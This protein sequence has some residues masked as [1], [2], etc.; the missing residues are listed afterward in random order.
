M[1]K[2]FHDL[3]NP[4]N[5]IIS[6]TQKVHLGEHNTMTAETLPLAET[7][8]VGKAE[9]VMKSDQKCSRNSLGNSCVSSDL[10]TWK[11]CMSGTN[12]CSWIF[13]HT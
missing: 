12:L 3:L 9:A 1:K 2:V 4:V 11:G 13:Y 7:S 6:D 5:L 8:N 10:V